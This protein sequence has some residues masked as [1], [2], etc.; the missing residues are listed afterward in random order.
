MWEQLRPRLERLPSVEERTG[1]KRTGIY[2]GIK[3]GTFPAPVR[4]G[5]RAVAWNSFDIDRWIEEKLKN[6]E[7]AAAHN[8]SSDMYSDGAEKG[9]KKIGS[10]QSLA[11]R[12][13][14]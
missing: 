14:K 4:I 8:D 2:E 6:A 1:K 5:D 10:V 12:G 3:E 13:G 11:G 7:R 9:S